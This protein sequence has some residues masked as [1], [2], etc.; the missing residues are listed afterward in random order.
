MAETTRRSTRV[1]QMIFGFQA[2]TGITQVNP[3]LTDLEKRSIEIGIPVTIAPDINIGDQFV[4]IRNS[5]TY[6]KVRDHLLYNFEKVDKMEKF[7][8]KKMPVILPCS[9]YGR[10]QMNEKALIIYMEL[11]RFSKYLISILILKAMT[12]ELRHE[13]IGPFNPNPNC[14]N[15]KDTF[16]RNIPQ[17]NNCKNNN[18]NIRY[19]LMNDIFQ[20]L[21]GMFANDARIAAA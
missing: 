18:N 10:E 14:K 3:N 1:A 17:H 9:F 8:S 21:F 12:T 4:A 19:K 6:T 7:M 2:G 15:I 16:F 13:P 5:L 20:D 11:Y